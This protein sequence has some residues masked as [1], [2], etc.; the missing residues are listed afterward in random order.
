M[1]STVFIINDS[2]HER[3]WKIRMPKKRWRYV[4]VTN[5]YGCEIQRDRKEMKRGVPR[6]RDRTISRME[7]V[8]MCNHR[9]ILSVV[10]TT[11]GGGTINRN[12]TI[13]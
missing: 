8:Y 1:C 7:T 3:D 11:M 2:A 6:K 5:G 10:N 12:Q 13:Q 4:S 9:S